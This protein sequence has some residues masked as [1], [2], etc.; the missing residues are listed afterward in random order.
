MLKKLAIFSIILVMLLAQPLQALAD[1]LKG[2][3][4]EPEMRAL[5]DLGIV[6]GNSQGNFLPNN[7]ITRGQFAIMISN[8]LDLPF[9][10]EPFTFEDTLHS[11]EL[12]DSIRRAQVVGIINGYSAT[13]FRPNERIT[14]EQMAA[15]ID[16]SLDYKNIKAN[17][18]AT[19]SF[20]DNESINA[21]FRQNVANNAYFGIIRGYPQA[22]NQFAFRPKEQATRA[23]A[24]AFIFRLLKVIESYGQPFNTFLLGTID[25]SGNISF[26]KTPFYNFNEAKEVFDP[27]KHDVISVNGEIQKMNEGIVVATPTPGSG[28]ILVIYDSSMRNNLTYVA[29]GASLKYLDATEDK[30][31]VQITGESTVGYVKKSEV[32]L[33]P[34]PLVK[35]THSHYEVANGE[36][37]HRVFDYHRGVLEGYVFGKAPSAM[38]N[39]ERYVSW[40]GIHFTGINNDNTITYRQ[41][42]NY[43]PLHTK[44]SYTAEQFNEY[45]EKTRP[46]SPLKNLGHV[47]KE[48]EELYGVNALYLFSKAVHESNWA[49]SIIAQTKNNL[50]GLNASDDDPEGNA[51]T[52]ESLEANI[53]FAARF[54]ANN[55][56]TFGNWR[57]S[58]AVLGNKS[59]GLNVRYASDP[60]WGQKIA[61]HM[62]R[63]DKNFGFQ[64]Y[65]K[66]DI[67]ITTGTTA[68][69]RTE[70]IVS[71]STLQFTYPRPGYY[72]AVL[73]ESEQNDGTWYQIY[74]DHKDHMHAY[75]RSD[76]VQKLTFE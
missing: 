59:T 76:L 16:R 18:N 67:A 27:T 19:A 36:L 74:S 15:M 32:L 70:P 47:F 31:K 51:D 3:T 41:Y 28:N 49:L 61:A 43:L 25:P 12:A 40:D 14:R 56:F 42:Y 55:Y 9:S 1:D 63:M 44:T 45:V 71:P 38:K 21:T 65:N 68:S 10:S 66:Y 8:A 75:V 11:Y 24:A 30:V 50:F 64:D 39:G 54:V 5:I 62:Y 48:A 72:V 13:E 37:I 35:S 60:F 52:F 46:N 4:L 53:M 58:G 6:R 22:N 33:I 17:G 26:D 23:H 73:A 2:H 29:N 20:T 7:D 34:Q 57:Y 69:V